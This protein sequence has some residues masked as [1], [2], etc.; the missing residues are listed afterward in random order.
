MLANNR[1]QILGAFDRL[2]AAVSELA[3]L[4]FDVLTTPE[5]LALLERLEQ[6]ARRLPIPRHELISPVS[7]FFTIPRS[8]WATATTTRPSGPSRV[9]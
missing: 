1:D 3:Q 4:S 9:M 6:E 5:R 8:Y 2:H 7:T